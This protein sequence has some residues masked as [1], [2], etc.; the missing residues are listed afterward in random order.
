MPRGTLLHDGF[1]AFQADF[2]EEWERII[3]HAP[4]RVDAHSKYHP[5]CHGLATAAE[6]GPGGNVNGDHRKAGGDAA[7]NKT[8]VYKTAT[9]RDFQIGNKVL[10]FTP[11]ISSSK[12]GNLDDAWTGLYEV[13]VKIS[14]MTYAI[15]RP[16]QRRKNTTVHVTAMKKWMPPIAGSSLLSTSDSSETLDLPNYTI[17]GGANFPPLADGLI[18][19]QVQEYKCWKEF[20]DATSLRLGRAKR[21]VHRM[22]HQ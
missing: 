16:D 8:L 17:E 22:P 13:L 6:A 19:Q 1:L 18:K 4:S 14:P 5:F 10:V 15:N 11:D 12:K 20:S 7:Q 2:L 3:R 9:I 21:A